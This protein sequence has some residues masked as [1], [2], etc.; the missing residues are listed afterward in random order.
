MLKRIKM[1]CCHL[2][3]LRFFI[4][5]PF[6]H[7]VLCGFGSVGR[8]NMRLCQYVRLHGVRLCQYVR[9]HGVRLCQY[10]RL[11]SVDGQMTA[12]LRIGKRR[13]WP[14]LDNVPKFFRRH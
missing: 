14:D 2:L 10:V 12:E 1:L 3:G 9:L 7:C 5:E 13:S 4:L 11:H 8:G 6:F